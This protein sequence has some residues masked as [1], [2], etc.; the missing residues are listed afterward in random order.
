LR[1]EETIWRIKSRSLWLHSG[2]KNTTFFHK[3]AR[4]RQ[5]KTKLEEIKTPTGETIQDFE[6]IKQH[7]TRF[8]SQLYMKSRDLDVDMRNK[9]ISHLP[10]LVS[11]EDNLELNKQ[12]EEEEIMKAINQFNPDKAQALMVSP[13][14]SLKDVGPLL[15][16]ITLDAQICPKVSLSRGSY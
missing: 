8:Y 15:N 11:E 13:F 5:W 2:D 12:V 7:A 1:D 10:Q 6:E 4:V 9:F 14:T 3:Q 16:L